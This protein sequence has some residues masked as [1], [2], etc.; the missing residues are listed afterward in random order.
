MFIL[1]VAQRMFVSGGSM[2]IIALLIDYY[3]QGKRLKDFNPDEITFWE[4]LLEPPVR[5]IKKVL[6][7]EDLLNKKTAR[8][9][10]AT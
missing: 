1:D 9:H 3:W 8:W 4:Y 7:Q 2:L 10:Y 6:I 5:V